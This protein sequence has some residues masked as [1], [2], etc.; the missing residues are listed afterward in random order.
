MYNVDT[1]NDIGCF[2]C[3]S[4]CMYEPVVSLGP[5][6]VCTSPKFLT[7][8]LDSVLSLCMVFVL[9]QDD[10]PRSLSLSISAAVR[11]LVAVCF[12]P[13]EMIKL[14]NPCLESVYTPPVMTRQKCLLTN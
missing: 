12:S 11:T 13:P 9:L 2:K 6:S 3:T 1:T 14:H 7:W 4:M 8:Y 10:G 5:L